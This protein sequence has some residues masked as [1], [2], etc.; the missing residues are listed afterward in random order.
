MKAHSTP[1]NTAHAL[2][3]DTARFGA[4]S[5]ARLT[6]GDAHTVACESIRDDADWYIHVRARSDARENAGVFN[7]PAIGDILCDNSLANTS[8]DLS[9]D[10]STNVE[11]IAHAGTSE[12]HHCGPRDVIHVLVR[13]NAHQFV[14][15]R[16]HGIV[17][18]HERNSPRGTTYEPIV[19]PRMRA[20]LKS[21]ESATAP[22]RCTDSI[23]KCLI[24]EQGFPRTA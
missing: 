12:C 4:L 3:L 6:G 24:Y 8:T 9:G 21:P 18:G 10:V 13:E 17:F 2:L 22:S 23:S 7:R 19:L 16:V 5:H 1:N 15:D 20:R 14:G 11:H